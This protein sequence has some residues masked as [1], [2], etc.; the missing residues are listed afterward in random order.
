MENLDEAVAPGPRQAAA[1]PFTATETEEAVMRAFVTWDSF[2]LISHALIPAYHYKDKASTNKQNI[3]TI[4]KCEPESTEKI[5]FVF[6]NFYSIT[7][8]TFPESGL[9]GTKP[10]QLL[11]TSEPR[12]ASLTRS[13]MHPRQVAGAAPHALHALSTF[14]SSIISI[15]FC[16]QSPLISLY[17]S[18]CPYIAYA[19]GVC[20]YWVHWDEISRA[21]FFP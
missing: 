2:H 11:C 5:C 19:I 6:L 21:R 14:P 13:L 17:D 9:L 16:C 3:S 10:F 8:I 20:F 15:L 1:W 18:F 12:A 4:S 7:R